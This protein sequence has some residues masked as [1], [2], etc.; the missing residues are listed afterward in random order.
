[1][2]CVSSAGQGVLKAEAV[3]RIDVPGLSR[4]NT[5]GV[6]T[7]A[8]PNFIGSSGFFYAVLIWGQ[9]VSFS[10]CAGFQ[11]VDPFPY[12]LRNSNCVL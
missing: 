7:A 10:L 9:I 11:L 4:V 12:L 5:Q 1:M 6:V 8:A 2:V 3:V